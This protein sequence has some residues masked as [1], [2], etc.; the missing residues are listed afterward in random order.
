MIPRNLRIFIVIALSIGLILY[1]KWDSFSNPQFWAE[2][3]AV[4]FQG[5]H[6]L[7]LPSLLR[8][9][10]GY[11]HFLQRL[12]AYAASLL[13]DWSWL[14]LV[15]ASLSLAAPVLIIGL[16]HS[17]RFQLGGDPLRAFLSLS[18]ALAPIH[19]AE[20]FGNLTNIHWILALI[21]PILMSAS[22]SDPAQARWPRFELIVLLLIGL[23]GP[24]SVLAAPFFVLCL[25]FKKISGPIWR[26]R[27]AVIALSA[28]I[29]SLAL[30]TASASVPHE[31]LQPDSLLSALGLWYTIAALR[32]PAYILGFRGETARVLALAPALHALLVIRLLFEVS[33]ARSRSER[34]EEPPLPSR[35]IIAVLYFQAALILA[36][37]VRIGH[38]PVFV[39]H[40]AGP[41]Y[42]FIPCVTML[43]SMLFLMAAHCRRA[44]LAFALAGLCLTLFLCG[45]RGLRA[46]QRPPSRWSQGLEELRQAKTGE[47]ITIPITPEGWIVE[48][49]RS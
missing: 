13:F 44:P 26:A 28:G 7:G 19:E 12:L 18:L 9:Y 49:R 46:P 21:Y 42:F 41:R 29:Q 16:I 36:A 23:T 22:P 30:L 38:A 2:D 20:V 48:V 8:P 24:F 35:A 34:P 31:R 40:W 14:P 5:A 43:W 1:R 27:V 17:P 45:H 47:R 37:L 6:E 11:H 3:G 33:R 32:V 15:Y 25:A 10:A 39:E 4:F